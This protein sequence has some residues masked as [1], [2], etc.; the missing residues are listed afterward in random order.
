MDTCLLKSITG[1][2]NTVIIGRDFRKGWNN[3][4]ESELGLFL[5]TGHQPVGFRQDGPFGYIP[6]QQ[7]FGE[8]HQPESLCS[9]VCSRVGQ[10][11]HRALHAGSSETWLDVCTTRLNLALLS[12][13]LLPGCHV[14]SPADSMTP[15][16]CTL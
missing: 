8:T 2:S 15:R 4:R 13:S 11:R 7:R 6:K 10:A 1:I 16:G 9:P 12:L 3:Q 14:K 5:V